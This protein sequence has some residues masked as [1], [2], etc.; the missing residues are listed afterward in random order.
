MA[1]RKKRRTRA[2]KWDKELAAILDEFVDEEK[3]TIEAIFAEVA[4]ETKE[5]VSEQA[6][7]KFKGEGDYAR[8][9]EVKNTGNMARGTTRLVVCNPKHYRLTHLLEKGHVSM[10]QYGGPYKRVRGKRHIKPSEK[11]A[12]E[13][14]MR[15]LKAEL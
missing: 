15:R 5:L 2:T 1:K 4:K 13:E 10:N 7:A 9:W 3:E 6:R 14:L 8:G 11:W 12:R